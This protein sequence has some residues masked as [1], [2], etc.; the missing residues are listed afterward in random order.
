MRGEEKAIEEV[1][2]PRRWNSSG[3]NHCSPRVR[4]KKKGYF[5]LCHRTRM[6]G[7]N[8]MSHCLVT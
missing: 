8:K 6:A 2:L 5:S 1:G 7:S 4:R 3:W